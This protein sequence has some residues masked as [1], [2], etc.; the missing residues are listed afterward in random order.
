MEKAKTLLVL[1]FICITIIAN[2]QSYRLSSNNKK[3]IKFYKQ[4]ESFY[5]QQNYAEAE[6]M[7]NKSL[8]YDDDFMEALLLLGDIFRDQNKTKKAIETYETVISKD[9]LFFTATYYFLGDLYLEEFEFEKAISVFTEFLTMEGISAERSLLAKFGYDKAVFRKHALQNP[10]VD[11]ITQ[12]DSSVN[13][14]QDEYVNYVNIDENHIIITIRDHGPLLVLSS[15]FR[16]FFAESKKQSGLWNKPIE[17]KLPPSQD[18]NMGGMNLSFD[19]KQMYFSGCN[20]PQGFGSCDIYTS[21]LNSGKWTNPT[22]LPLGLNSNSWDS[23][24]SISANGNKLYFASNRTGGKGGSDIWMSIKLKTG[25]WSPAI[26]LGDSIN[27]AGNEM[28]PFIHADGK[29][30]YYSTDGTIGMGG[31]DILISQKLPTGQWTKGKNLGYPINTNGDEINLF[32]SIDGKKAWMSA[33]RE[34]GKGGSD[35]YSFDFPETIKPKEIISLKGIVVDAD[36]NDFLKATIEI[37]DLKSGE[38]LSLSESEASNGEFLSVLFP[39][40][41]YA[42]NISRIGY[43]FYS[44]NLKFSKEEE[45]QNSKRIFKLQKIQKGATADLQNIYFDS[46]KWKIK[47][48]S[49]IELNKLVELLNQNPE[50][51][52]LIEGHTDNTGENEYNQKLSEKRAEAIME[53]LI[54]NSIKPSNLKFK[55]YGSEKP[56]AENTTDKGKSLNRRTSIKVL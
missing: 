4:A 41:E 54:E 28:A 16:E 26:N 13:S 35:I 37:T 46:D 33:N 10:I 12:L 25:K 32:A 52:I 20:W 1:L 27:T 3:A 5:V 21:K 19:G 56:I 22:L 7:I 15:H 6:K 39:D 2:S 29:T 55:G 8:K 18:Q 38:L 40:R 31:F 30:L 45:I 34:N 44:G 47:K 14:P 42:I 23:Q 50:L 24:A 11:N 51:N 9:P 43:F 17:I 36:K 49:F 53:Y 48:E